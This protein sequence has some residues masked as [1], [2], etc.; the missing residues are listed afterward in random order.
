[1]GMR[2]SAVTRF[3]VKSLS[4]IL[5][6]HV[7]RLLFWCA[8]YSNQLGRRSYKEAYGRELNSHLAL[9]DDLRAFSLPW[10]ISLLIHE[11][12]QECVNLANEAICNP[13]E[14]EEK[15]RRF[16]EAIPQCFK[17][18]AKSKIAKDFKIFSTLALNAN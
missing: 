13:S 7:K 8:V 18:S 1:M 5:P 9:V 10:T 11:E 4:R 6:R 3:L 14:L 15:A 16:S 2:T 17:Y 12:V